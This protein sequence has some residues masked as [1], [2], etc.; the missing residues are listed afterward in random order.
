MEK[1]FEI[2]TEASLW[3]L[4][5]FQEILL[6]L[7]NSVYSKEPCFFCNIFIAIDR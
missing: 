7:Y 5:K 3:I 6:N 2:P 1:L 4:E